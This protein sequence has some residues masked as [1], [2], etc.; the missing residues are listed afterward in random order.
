MTPEHSTSSFKESFRSSMHLNRIIFNC[1][2]YFIEQAECEQE[3]QGLNL[4]NNEDTTIGTVDDDS[5]V[6]GDE[7]K[8]NDP[9][10]HA[11]I[12]ASIRADH[13]AK[14]AAEHLMD[15]S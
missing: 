3:A 14:V 12:F 6:N 11:N 8:T 13:I 1:F 7:R 9:R 5:I 2:S 4:S 10:S 15:F